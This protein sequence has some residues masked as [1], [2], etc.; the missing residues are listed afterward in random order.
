MPYTMKALG[1]LALLLLTG[2]ATVAGFHSDA[3]AQKR[4]VPPSREVA[5][6]SFSPIVRRA[7]PAVRPRAEER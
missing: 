5:Q 7:A 3:R 1:A 4:E 6:Y 2:L